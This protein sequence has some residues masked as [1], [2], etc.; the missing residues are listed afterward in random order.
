MEPDTLIFLSNGEKHSRLRKLFLEAIHGFHVTADTPFVKPQDPVAS[1]ATDM[2]VQ[3][4]LVRNLFNRLFEEL[5]SEEALD[6]LM[7]YYKCGVRA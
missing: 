4:V 5:P 1:N 6:S 7:D 2:E 3:R